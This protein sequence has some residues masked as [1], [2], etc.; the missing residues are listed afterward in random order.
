[1][2]DIKDDEYDKYN[3]QSILI[4]L[5]RKKVYVHVCKKNIHHLY[6]KFRPLPRI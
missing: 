5:I 2:S 1:M 3:K 6:E 4:T